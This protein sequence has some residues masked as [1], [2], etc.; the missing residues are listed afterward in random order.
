MFY[1]SCVVSVAAVGSTFIKELHRFMFRRCCWMSPKRRWKIL[2]NISFMNLFMSMARAVWEANICNSIYRPGSSASPVDQCQSAQA[3]PWIWAHGA[4]KH[5]TISLLCPSG[6]KEFINESQ[7]IFYHFSIVSENPEICYS[8]C[9][10]TPFLWGRCGGCCL[11]YK[12][13]A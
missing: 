1:L 12:E 13:P 10:E 5:G 4:L 6:K 8:H 3:W 9:N 11:V 7:C 2:Q